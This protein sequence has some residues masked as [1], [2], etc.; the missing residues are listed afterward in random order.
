[1]A[2]PQSAEIAGIRERR[3]WMLL[4]P[5]DAITGF[6]ICIEQDGKAYHGLNFFHMGS[7]TGSVS[8]HCHITKNSI[9]AISRSLFYP[10]DST[11]V[12]LAGK[13]N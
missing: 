2:P 3:L 10:E 7:S 5:Y 8:V 6:R 9:P 1:M 13:R 11:N 4:L 12:C